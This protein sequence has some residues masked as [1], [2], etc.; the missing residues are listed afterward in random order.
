[1]QLQTRRSRCLIVF[2]GISTQEW[3]MYAED[4]LFNSNYIVQ[5]DLFEVVYECGGL[6]VIS[7][8]TGDNSCS[9]LMACILLNTVLLH[10]V[11]KYIRNEYVN[12][13]FKICTG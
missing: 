10:L 4:I 2:N 5:I 6:E 1:M 7:D 13:R 3:L 9:G 12:A 11:F 8:K